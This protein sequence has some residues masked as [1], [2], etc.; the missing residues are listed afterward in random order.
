MVRSKCMPA[1]SLEQIII[2]VIF[3]VISLHKLSEKHGPVMLL[4]LGSKP[5]VV[6]SSVDAARDIMKT[7]D[8]VWSNRPKSKMADRLFY[9]SK[10]VAFSPYGEYWRQVRSVT[11]LHLLSNKRVQSFR[12]VLEEEISNMIENIRQECEFSRSVIDLRDFFCSLTNTIISRVAL[13]RKYNEGESGINGNA[14]LDGFVN[15][16]GT[17]NVGEYIPWL[18]WFNKISGLDTKVE[19]AAKETD[20]FLENVIEEHIRKGEY[21][22]GEAKDFVDVLLEIQINGDETGYPLQ[23]D[24]LK[25]ILLKSN[26]ETTPTVLMLHPPMDTFAVGTDTTY[27]A[28]EWIITELYRHPRA[29]KK[30]QKE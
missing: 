30:L 6:A 25:A 18:E 21:R 12:D 15:L 17:F 19:K 14:T 9:G 29:M 24:S 27:T 22:S 5:M 23:R 26:G 7:H 13:G 10:D 28:L 2:I 11:V 16:L 3:C 4:H 8:L 1:S 20:T